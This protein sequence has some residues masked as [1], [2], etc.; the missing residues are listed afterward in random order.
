[1]VVFIKATKMEMVKKTQRIKGK[2]PT[3]LAF[4]HPE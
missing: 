2:N 1:M 3:F 4:L